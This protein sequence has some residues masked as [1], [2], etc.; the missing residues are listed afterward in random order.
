MITEMKKNWIMVGEGLYQG[1]GSSFYL[2]VGNEFKYC[3]AARLSKLK[4]Q[5]GD[6][7]NVIAN[8]KSRGNKKQED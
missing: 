8:Y 6:I 5:Y 7:A 2:K 4:E 3:S 1:G